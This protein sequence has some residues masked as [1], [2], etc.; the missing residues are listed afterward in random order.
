MSQLNF[1]FTDN[2]IKERLQYILSTGDYTIFVG[3]FFMTET[4]NQINNICDLNRFDSLTI[5]VNNEFCEPICTHKG[6]GVYS[7]D[8]LFDNYKDPIIELDNCKLTDK[9]I[10]AGRLYFKSGWI[11]NTELN[12][13]HKKMANKLVRFFKKDLVSI[14]SPFMISSEIEELIEKGFEIE[15]GVGGKRINKEIKNA[16]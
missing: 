14:S 11:A 10:T 7:N 5:W 9:L 16:L 2:E 15:L 4:P 3:R 1:F 13:L 8:F 6:Q 12:Q